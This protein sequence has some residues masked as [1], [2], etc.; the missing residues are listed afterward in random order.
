MSGQPATDFRPILTAIET[1]L[2]T[3]GHAA[4]LVESITTPYRAGDIALVRAGAEVVYTPSARRRHKHTQF[5]LTD[6]EFRSPVI[7][8]RVLSMLQQVVKGPVLRWRLER[9]HNA[10][11]TSAKPDGTG[12][13]M[14]MHWTL[15]LTYADDNGG[16]GCGMPLSSASELS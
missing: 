4:Y 10:E 2:G 15:A 3:R 5:I 11:D 6:N 9:W 13:A 16:C 7:R 12:F 8:G 1:G 14:G